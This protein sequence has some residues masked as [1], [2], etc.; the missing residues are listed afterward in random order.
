MLCTICGYTL[1]YKISNDYLFS[2][3]EIRV[4]ETFLM[5]ALFGWAHEWWKGTEDSQV[6]S[7]VWRF[8]EDPCEMMSAKLKIYG[9]FPVILGRSDFCSWQVKECDISGF[10][11]IISSNLRSFI[12]L[13]LPEWP[14]L[15]KS[16]S[17]VK[18]LSIVS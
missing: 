7:I 13:N 17:W 4:G 6:Q 9:R 11:E 12:R 14:D 2:K 3:C 15:N 16:G 10:S 18:C 5:Q 8:S 1:E